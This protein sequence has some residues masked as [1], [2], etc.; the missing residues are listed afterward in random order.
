MLSQKLINLKTYVQTSV[1]NL[2][3]IGKAIK[4]RN[5]SDLRISAKVFIMHSLI[6]KI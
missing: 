2:P 4:I 3:H 1:S 6:K 5:E